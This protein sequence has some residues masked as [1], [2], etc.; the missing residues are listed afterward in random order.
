MKRLL[1]L[2]AFIS[3]AL[4]GFAAEK[5]AAPAPDSPEAL[6]A[7]MSQPRWVVILGVYKEFAEAKADAL[8]FSKASKVP[9]SMRGNVFDKKGLHFPKDIDDPLYAGQYVARSHNS[10]MEDKKD[11]EEHLSVERSDG[12][13]GFAKGYYIVVG[14]IAE[15]AKDGLAQ[16]ERFKAFSKDTYVKKTI[17]YLGCMH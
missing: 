16:A 11:L 4:A 10:S 12:Y 2:L 17:I 1:T 6:E 14:T 5:K 15:T 13:Q 7:Q 8:K 3:C 9:F